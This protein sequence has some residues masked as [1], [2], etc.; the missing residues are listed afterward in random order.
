MNGI[1]KVED[2]DIEHKGPNEVSH[3]RMNPS[4]AKGKKKKKRRQNNQ[5]GR[6][7]HY[8]TFYI[9][10]THKWDKC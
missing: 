7:N 5:L 2:A 4:T 8:A 1:H 9:E 6:A 10:Y 3:F